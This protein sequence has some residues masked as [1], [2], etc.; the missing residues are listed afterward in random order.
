MALSNKASIL[1]A[2]VEQSDFPVCITT[3]ELEPPGPKIVYV[4]EPL[5]RMTG[6]TREELVGSTPRIHQGPATERAELD[7]LKA[8]LR[9]G[10]AFEGHTW[11]TRKDGTAFQVQWTVTPLRLTGEGID[12]FFAVQRDLT[13]QYPVQEGLADETRRMSALL[14]SAGFGES[15]TDL[16]ARLADLIDDLEKQVRERTRE[17]ESARDHFRSIL[18]S[19]PVGIGFFDHQRRIQRVNPALEALFGYSADQLLGREARVLYCDQSEFERV[20]REAYPRMASGGVYRTVV[21]LKHAD[22]TPMTVSLKGQAVNPS[23]DEGFIWALQDITEQCTREQ[24]LQTYQAVFESSRDAVTLTTEDGFFVDCNPAA[25]ALFEV[26]DRATFA[27]DYSPATLSPSYQPDGRPSVEAVQAFIQ[28]SLEQGQAFFEWHHRST[29]GRTFPAE[30]QLSRVDLHDRLIFEATVRDVSEQ[31]AAFEELRQARDR[32]ET[33]FEA[34]P[35]MELILDTQGHVSAIN[36]RGCDLLGLAREAIVGT[37]WFASFIAGDKEDR[38]AEVHEALREDREKLTEYVEHAVN[39]AAGE[40]RIIAFRS[41]LLRDATG[42]V[43]GLLASGV[44]VTESRQMEATLEYQASHDPLTGV[45]NRR[46]MRELVDGAIQRGQRYGTV[47]SVILFDIDHFKA[48]NDHHGHEVGDRILTEL[49]TVVERRLRDVDSLARWG[50]EEFLVLLPE[51]D[52]AGA[53]QAAEELRALTAATDF[54]AVG[55]VTISLGVAVFNEDEAIEGL[56]KRVDN[57]VYAA[58]TG[59]RNRVV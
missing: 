48:V 29:T 23:G 42:Q 26:A 45:Y 28:Q 19:S 11:N 36:Q 58:K 33:Y 27:R 12:Y 47:F 52:L 24:A 7:R 41:I 49:I 54:T 39:A 38:L 18:N 57:N 44:D 15:T 4:N 43:E 17:A 46:R 40:R 59:G 51:T 6:Y 9:A 16:S 56:L 8:N 50:G 5:T 22:G 21:T 34:A 35:V 20:G 55:S 1:E 14:H 32:A 30:I 31:K 10:D 25:L 3:A 2:A 37:D 13:H 53:R